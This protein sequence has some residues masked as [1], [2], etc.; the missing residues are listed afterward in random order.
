MPI[1]PQNKE[2]P[3]HKWQIGTHLVVATAYTAMLLA[4]TLVIR[5]R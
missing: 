1:P 5:N 4:V 3:G 2:Q